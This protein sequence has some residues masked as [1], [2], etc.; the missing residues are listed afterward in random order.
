[1]NGNYYR[2]KL[3]YKGMDEKGFITS[4]KS[5]DL[6]MATCYTEAEQVAYKLA[7]GKD[8]YGNVEIE[9]IKTKINEVVFNNAFSVAKELTHGLIT[10]YF[11][12]SENSEVGLYAVTIV[13]YETNETNGKDK[14]TK[15]IIFIPASSSKE[16]I[17][18]IHATLKK[19]GE[20]RDWVIRNIKYDKAQSVLVT[21]ETHQNNLQ[22]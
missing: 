2:I 6:V 10:Y 3:A 1:M 17:D 15:E 22:A 20:S 12:E 7:E 4:I 5:E 13:Y 21:P 19:L 9:I 11:K 18:N 8:E 16:A 14:Q